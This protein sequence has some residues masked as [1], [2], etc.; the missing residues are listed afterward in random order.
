MALSR[1]YPHLLF[2]R[3]WVLNKRCLIMLGQCVSYV[4]AISNTPIMPAY[5]KE[6][7]RISLIKG[8]QATTAI[9][10]NTLTEEDI[11]R[12]NEGEK[13]PP[14]KE[15]LEIEVKNII[16]AFNAILQETVYDQKE[17]LITSE[18]ILRLHKMVGKDLGEHF[19][20]IPGRFREN[21]VNVGKYRCPDH[22]DVPE[23]I[24]RYCQWMREEFRF[25]DGKQQFSDVIEQAIV[26]HLYLEWIHPFGDGNGRTGR[27]IEFYVLSRGGNPDIALHILSNHY[28]QT[29]SDYYR[30]IDK[31]YQSRDLSAFIEY[32]LVG[33]RDGLQQ[34]L[35]KIQESQLVN[36][37]QKYVYDTFEDVTITQRNIFKRRRRLA[38]EMPIDRKFQAREIA[39]LSIKLAQL[40]AGV[41]SRTLYRDLEELIHLQL[42]NQEGNEYFANISALSSFIARRKGL[43]ATK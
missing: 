41:S 25:E 14:S 10:G 2:R 13:L 23:L 5:Y 19:A 36:T 6:L 28:N 20:A 3:H 38:L 24:Q 7:M 32:A 22:R 9:E 29:R 39:G 12:I 8:A 40:Y 42:L 15:Y 33:L 35:E 31:A 26:A 1:E 27:L 4:K 11:E 30:Q 16:T 37:W 17:E 21:E 34:T 18:L 43:V